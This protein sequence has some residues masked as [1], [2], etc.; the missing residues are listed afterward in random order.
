M[1]GRHWLVWVAVILIAAVGCSGNE[2]SPQGPPAGFPTSPAGQVG[3]PGGTFSFGDEAKWPDFVPQDIPELE[4]E[5]S[6]VMSAPDFVRIF[7]QKV[8]QRDLFRYLDQLEDAGF[9]LQ[10]VVY[11]D[12]WDSDD[13]G[14]QVKPQ[15]ADAVEITKGAY[16]MKIE[17]GADQATYDIYTTGF[18]P[19]HPQSLI[20]ST[21]IVWPEDIPAQISPPAN[22]DPHSLARIGTGGYQITFVCS[23]ADVQSQFVQAMLSAGLQETDRLVSDRGEIVE[24][25]L[26][27][28]EIAV[29]AMGAVHPYF[30]IQVWPV[31]P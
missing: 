26:Q 27:D 13:S 10:Y 29:K 30:T 23:D 19:P 28:Q 4:G 9:E 1:K 20:T 14:K 18:M 31:A 12:P 21:P 8:P 3:G 25:T 22:C 16:R 2:N 6:T 24:I 17:Y 5:I 7:Y 11:V 15:D